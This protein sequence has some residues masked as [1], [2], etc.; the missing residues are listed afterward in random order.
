LESDASHLS[1]YRRRHTTPLLCRCP[2]AGGLPVGGHSKPSYVQAAG[3]DD[4][5]MDFRAVCEHADPG[6]VR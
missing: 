3:A 6:V 2:T 4:G 1:C 5:G